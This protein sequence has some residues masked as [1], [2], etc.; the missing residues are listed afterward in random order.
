KN[1]FDETKVAFVSLIIQS[2]EQ[3]NKDKDMLKKQLV[4]ASE[5]RTSLFSQVVTWLENFASHAIPAVVQ[6][7]HLIENL[8]LSID[9]L[10]AITGESSVPV[11]ENCL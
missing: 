8:G 1:E 6:E 9:D 2:Y 4:T 11:P 10:Y 7:P 3:V 5:E